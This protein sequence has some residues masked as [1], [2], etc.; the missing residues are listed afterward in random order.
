MNNTIHYSPFDL[1]IAQIGFGCWQIGGESSVNG[2][3]NGWGPV[4]DRESIET[5]QY[6]LDNGINFFDT[7]L[8][9]GDGH[10]E[11]ILGKATALSN[12]TAFI[13][14]KFGPK[15]S[16]D[17]KVSSDFSAENLQLSVEQSLGRLKREAIDLLLLHNPAIDFDWKTYDP[18]PFENLIKE[19]KIKSF[20][21]SCKTHKAAL[22]VVKAKFG[23][24]VEVIYNPIDRRAADELMPLCE[25]AAY[26]F[27][28]RVPL[29]SGF[30]TPK[31]LLQSRTFAQT[32]I[33]TTFSEEQTDW[34]TDCAHKLA[35]L[36]DLEGG[37]AVSG[38]RFQLATNTG[39]AIPGMRK[40][41]YVDDVLKA[42]ELGP[43][44]ESIVNQIKE[45]VPLT[46]HRWR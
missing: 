39:V 29:A 19:G 26:L 35:F 33:R 42:F 15:Q 18:T 17:G 8:A 46:F 36:N 20:G 28:A 41:A 6:A 3:I 9:Y 43:L 38:L 12:Q 11:R 7:A 30:L 5:I 45:T 13:C 40:K 34:M 16:P 14:T 23:K 1:P 25:E 24:A 10:S 2:R 4:D 44:E 27:I 31:S 21:V 22:E 37:M 32:D